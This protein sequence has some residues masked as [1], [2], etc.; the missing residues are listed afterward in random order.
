MPATW[1]IWLRRSAR[2]AAPRALWPE[3]ESIV[4]LG[5]NYA[6]EAIRW[7][8]SPRRI[9]ANISVYAR[10]RDYHD[11]IKGRL[12][13]LA[14]WLAAQAGERRAQS[15]RRYRAGDGKAAGASRRASAGRASTPISSRANS[16]PG[17]FSARSS[18]IW[19]SR[20]T[21]RKQIIAAPAAP[22]STSARRRPFRS[23]ICSMRG[24]ASP[25]SRSSTRAIS[26]R[27]PRSDRQPH[28]WLRRLPCGL[29]VEQIRADRA[30][31]Q[32]AGARRSSRAAARGFA[33]ARRCGLSRALL[34]QSGEAHRLRALHAQCSDRRGQF[35]AMRRSRRSSKRGSTIL[36]RSCAAWRSGRSAGSRRRASRNLRRAGMTRR[37]RR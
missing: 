34:R 36:R 15:L 18:P 19:R 14:S 23:P 29:P 10:H 12:K 8:C 5:M 9:A 16:A 33:R 26:R 17:C 21:R 6:P 31:S 28:L 30:R 20:R 13:L 24:A 25:I 11:L 27:I 1:T 22:A 35:A 3:V 32:A 2:R 37:M 7:R 4:M